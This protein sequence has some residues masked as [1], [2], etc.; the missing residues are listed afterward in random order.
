MAPLLAPHPGLVLDPVEL[1]RA[2]R[3]HEARVAVPGVGRAAED[4]GGDERAVGVVQAGVF[5][6]IIIVGLFILDSAL[7][8]LLQIYRGFPVAREIPLKGFFGTPKGEVHAHEAP[9]PM[10]IG[11][12]VTVTGCLVLFFWPDVLY[13]LAAAGAGGA[14]EWRILP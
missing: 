4:V 11:L 1:N 14:P 9:W 10:L 13:R 7:N 6:Y 2:P 5:I 8:A 12:A 3:P